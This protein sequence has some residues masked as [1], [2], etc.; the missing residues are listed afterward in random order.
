MFKQLLVQRINQINQSVAAIY[1]NI[2]DF[3]HQ[4]PALII[5][6]ELLIGTVRQSPLRTIQKDQLTSQLQNALVALRRG[7]AAGFATPTAQLDVVLRNMTTVYI[8]IAGLNN[9]G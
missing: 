6:L 1:E 9:R 8:M 7:T 5:Q 3:Q 4:K 2:S